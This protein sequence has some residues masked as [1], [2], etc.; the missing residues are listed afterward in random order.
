MRSAWIQKHERFNFVMF[1]L[2]RSTSVLMSSVYTFAMG[3]YVLKMTG[4][5]LSFAVTLSLQILPAVL[6]GPFAGVLADRFNK[7]IIVVLTDA[8]QGLLFAGLFFAAGNGLTLFDIYTATL[9]LAVSQTLYNVCMDSAVPNLVSGPHVLTVNSIGKIVDSAAGIVSPGLGG[10]L[11]A[12]MEIRYFVLLNG[13]AF[14]LSTVTECLIDFRLYNHLTPQNSGF[15]FKRELAAGFDYIKK[16]D[17]IKSSLRNFVTVNF[18]LAL[19]YSVPVPYILN[20]VFHL[21]PKAFGLVQCFSPVGMIVGALL[22]GK[23]TGMMSYGKLMRI[24]G[25]FCALC[26]VLLGALPVFSDHVAPVLL[27]P[28]YAFV[29]ACSGFA[30]SLIDIPFINHFQTR[31]PEELRGRSLSLSISAVKIATPAGYILS[32]VMMEIFPAYFLPF[33]GGILLFVLYSAVKRK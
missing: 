28:Y 26:L 12:A 7:K 32:G 18:F 21:S 25:A 29:L 19:C 6:I 2:G 17:W 1:F 5:G 14:F 27:I 10:V 3:L 9:L 22:V 31:V 4:S 33:C 13:I 24:S 30:V 16:S 15:D 11:Y 20:N 23:I 8:F